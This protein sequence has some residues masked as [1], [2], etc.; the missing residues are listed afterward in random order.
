MVVCGTKYHLIF[1]DLAI[2]LRITILPPK[3]DLVSTIYVYMYVI[4]YFKIII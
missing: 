2:Y 1:A 4:Y 3:C